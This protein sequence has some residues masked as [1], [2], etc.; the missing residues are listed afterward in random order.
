[1]QNYASQKKKKDQRQIIF[2]SI[3]ILKKFL[4][5]LTTKLRVYSILFLFEL[6]VAWYDE[7]G[8]SVEYQLTPL[9]KV[10]IHIEKKSSGIL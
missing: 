5:A 2:L 10:T 9:P 4:L 1:M 3:T 6:S 7:R 8:T